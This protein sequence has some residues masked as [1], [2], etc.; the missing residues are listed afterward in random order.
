MD[1]QNTELEF[2]DVPDLIDPDNLF[3]QIDLTSWD[4]LVSFD[5]MRE[6]SE[7]ALGLFGPR[8]SD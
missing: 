4:A 6:Y 3:T 2:D 8:A 5:I 7:K 1:L